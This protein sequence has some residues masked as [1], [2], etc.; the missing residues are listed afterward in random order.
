M[1]S[2]P[3]IALAVALIALFGVMVNALVAANNARKR[4]ELDEKLIQLKATLDQLNAV[5]M[6]KV[7]AEFSERLKL[8]EFDRSKQTADDDRKRKADA[9]TLASILKTLEPNGIIAFL[10]EHDFGGLFNRNDIAP[11]G[12]FIDQASQPDQEFLTSEL[13]ELRSRLVLLGRTLSN[14]IGAKTYPRH[15]NF[16]SVLPENLVNVE[17]PPVIRENATKLND[18]ATDFVDSFDELVRKARSI[19]GA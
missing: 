16:N 5:E 12:R 19:L 13:E 17:R 1:P 3:E 18:T 6:A 4:G 14:L 2:T 8:L 10:R 7:Q 11:L 15:G 9:A